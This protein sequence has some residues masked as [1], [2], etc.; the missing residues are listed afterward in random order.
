MYISLC[1]PPTVGVTYVHV[2]RN[3]ENGKKKGKRQVGFC[4]FV[5]LRLSIVCR[6]FVKVLSRIFNNL[7]ENTVYVFLDKNFW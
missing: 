1:L 7:Q 6:V 5:K 3:I 2:L 4:C